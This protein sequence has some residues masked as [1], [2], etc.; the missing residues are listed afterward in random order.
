MTS[1][2][3]YADEFELLLHKS[4]TGNESISAATDTIQQ[5]QELLQ[6][7]AVEARST[8]D[9]RQRKYYMDRY[10]AYKHQYQAMKQQL[11]RA[12]L[13]PVATTSS[14]EKAVQDKIQTNEGTLLQ[15]NSTLQQSLQSIHT[16]EQIA[17][18]TMEHLQNQRDTL[19]QT[20]QKTKGLQSM[21]QQANQVA[22]NL[23]K[24]WWRK[25]V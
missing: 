17:N 25:G 7:M 3:T 2:D 8:D 1:F 10:T 13:L 20:Q 14:N 4:S 24:P 22:T 19:Q 18:E 6:Q 9:Q 21:T 16:T 23:L 12:S 15:Q 11:D 5:C